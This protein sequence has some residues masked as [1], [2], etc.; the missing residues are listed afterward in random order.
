MDLEAF[1]AAE[2]QVAAIVEVRLRWSKCECAKDL[3]VLK[4]WVC[5]GY[6]LVEVVGVGV[7]RM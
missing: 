2:A 3:N 1:L 4:S 7:Q 5:E 6:E